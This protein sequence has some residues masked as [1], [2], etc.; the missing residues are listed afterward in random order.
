MEQIN[1]WV[2]FGYRPYATRPGIY[3]IKS[4]YFSNIIKN[5]NKYTLN[6]IIYEEDYDN[7]DDNSNPI[8]IGY[9]AKDEERLMMVIKNGT[10]MDS[11]EIYR[12]KQ[13]ELEENKNKIYLNSINPND[14]DIC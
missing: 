7:Y 8:Y 9:G 12:M 14:L 10:C 4:K 5:N 6:N 11:S 3:W 1:C 2:L 13:N